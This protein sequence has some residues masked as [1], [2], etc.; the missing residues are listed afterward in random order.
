MTMSSNL[1]GKLILS[2]PLS[3]LFDVTTCQVGHKIT[4]PVYINDLAAQFTGS[5]LDRRCDINFNQPVATRPKRIEL[6]PLRD[7]SAGRRE[8]VASVKR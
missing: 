7:P 6:D 8:D 3:K 1:C 5:L 2:E 4:K